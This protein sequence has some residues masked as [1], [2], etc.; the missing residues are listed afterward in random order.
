M[1]GETRRREYGTNPYECY[2]LPDAPPFALDHR[3]EVAGCIRNHLSGQRLTGDERDRL[4]TLREKSEDTAVR[5]VLEHFLYLEHLAGLAKWQWDFLQRLL[6]L[7][8]SRHSIVWRKGRASSSVWPF[9]LVSL[10]V[11]VLVLA[12]Y[13][14]WPFLSCGFVL[15]LIGLTIWVR[16][17]RRKSQ[18]EKQN[19][20]GALIPFGSVADVKFVCEEVGF[21]K[22]RYPRKALE[23]VETGYRM[24]PAMLVF[25]FSLVPGIPTLVMLA[26]TAQPRATVILCR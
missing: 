1:G 11:Q 21:K 2:E 8:E 16:L 20:E 5:F 10:V 25:L 26:P 15:N 14:L 12:S 7:C 13:G 24:T 23:P 19:R 4:W 9:G 22:Q 18:V 6:L 3:D 17:K